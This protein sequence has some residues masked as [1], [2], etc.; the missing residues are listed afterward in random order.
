MN[1]NLGMKARKLARFDLSNP[2]C[3]V[4]AHQLAEREKMLALANCL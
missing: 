1:L 4:Q 3:A 2:N